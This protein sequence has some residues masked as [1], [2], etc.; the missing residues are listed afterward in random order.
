[1]AEAK[2][3][4]QPEDT[5]WQNLYT[6]SSIAA[7]KRVFASVVIAAFLLLWNVPVTLI[8]SLFAADKLNRRV[9]RLE[10]TS[11]PSLRLLLTCAHRCFAL[12][13]GCLARSAGETSTLSS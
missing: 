8:Q 6:P 9:A 5:E 7:Y 2:P 4:P 1:M 11:S 13:P 3:A 12:A 10:P